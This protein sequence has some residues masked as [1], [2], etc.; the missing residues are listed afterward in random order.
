MEHQYINRAEIQGIVGQ[1]RIAPTGDGI[2]ATFT[3][4]TNH[5]FS[6][7]DGTPVIETTCYVK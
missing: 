3:V 6:A 1:V 5:S 2:I 7:K 4:A